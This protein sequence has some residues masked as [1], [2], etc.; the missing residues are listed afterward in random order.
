MF[1]H[2]PGMVPE[3]WVF[4]ELRVANLAAKASALQRQIQ[5]QLRDP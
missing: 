2:E 4:R 5:L 3:H 1:M